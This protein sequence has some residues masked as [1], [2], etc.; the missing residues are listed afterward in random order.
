MI[1]TPLPGIGKGLGVRFFAV[2]F[3]Q[4]RTAILSPIPGG[5]RYAIAPL[6]KTLGK[7][8]L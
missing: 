7:E 6:S 1:L 3:T 4:R 5:G 8:V 2:Y